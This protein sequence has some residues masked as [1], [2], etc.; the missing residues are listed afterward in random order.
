MDSRVLRRISL[1][2]ALAL[3]ATAIAC[4]AIPFEERPAAGYTYGS[5]QPL[6]VAIVDEAGGDWSAA[7]DH[8]LRSYAS[9]TPHLRFERNAQ[10]AN[11]T[12]TFR[13]YIESVPP[14]LQGYSFPQGAGGF[15]AVYDAR[16]IACNYPPSTL[17][18]SCS[19]EIATAIVYLNDELPP[20]SDIDTRRDRLV[21]HELGHALGLTRHNPDLDIAALSLRYGWGDD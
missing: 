9:A 20:G 2:A 6:T 5:G 18:L 11:I 14:E 15:A 21:L 16:G 3:A 8:A 1:L 12:V 4:G 10:A 17:P 7:I 13:G 19:G